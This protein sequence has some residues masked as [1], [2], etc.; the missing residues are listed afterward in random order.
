[1]MLPASPGSELVM[2]AKLS[3]TSP[4]A[5]LIEDKSSC[6][7]LLSSSDINFPSCTTFER[8]GGDTR[9]NRHSL[10]LQFESGTR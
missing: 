9:D 1:M 6:P 7:A 3:F 5:R 8:R 4:T 10:A 2:L